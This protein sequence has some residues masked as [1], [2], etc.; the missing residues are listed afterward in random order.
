MN[1]A[2]PA[3]LTVLLPAEAP[4]SS[5]SPTAPHPVVSTRTRSTDDRILQ[6]S[7]DPSQWSHTIIS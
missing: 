5:P 7:V 4:T 1:C 2:V 3:P 6:T